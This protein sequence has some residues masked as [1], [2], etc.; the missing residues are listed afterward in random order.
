MITF[1]YGAETTA[2]SKPATFTQ[3]TRINS[4]GGIQIDPETIDASALEDAVEKTVA[5]R[6]ST[7]GQFT[8]AVNLTEDTQDE[9]E[10]LIASYQALSGGK[11]MWFET[12]IPGFTDAFFVIAQPPL[13]IPQPEFGQNEL[14]TVDINLTIVD[15]KG[16]DT[17]VA[18]T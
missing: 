10:A 17:K 11:Q 5:G 4:I 1:G 6:G 14:L 12:I 18:F 16:L 8:V 13:S 9:W 3:L 15:Y 2:G 7:G